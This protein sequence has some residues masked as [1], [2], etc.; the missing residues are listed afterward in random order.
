METMETGTKMKTGW[1]DGM[2]DGKMDDEKLDGDGNQY[3]RPGG[4]MGCGRRR[5]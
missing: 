1:Q 5:R 3:G 4:N 2:P